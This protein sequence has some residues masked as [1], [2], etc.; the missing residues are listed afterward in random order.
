MLTT[1]TDT[2]PPTATVSANKTTNGNDTFEAT[3]KT[4]TALDYIDGG[5][6][7]DKIIIKDA[8]S[9]M[10]TAV[11]SGITLKSVESMEIQTAGSLGVAAVTG[12]PAQAAVKAVDTY[13]IPSATLSSITV[14]YTGVATD[15]DT[16]DV[17][18]DGAGA[19]AATTLTYVAA[20]GK[21]SDATPTE[22]NSLAEAVAAAV[23][24]QA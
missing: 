16:L 2:S 13:T 4:F 10:N 22:Y 1:G 24:A 9:V 7:T 8:D 20:S 19:G 3:G 15:G 14:G 6:G 5:E 12:Q 18:A 17:D 11:P 23:S 21:W